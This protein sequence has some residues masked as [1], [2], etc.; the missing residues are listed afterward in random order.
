MAAG[1]HVALD[2]FGLGGI[3]DGAEKEGFA[4]LAA[5]VLGR[6]VLDEIDLTG[7]Q[8]GYEK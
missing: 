5:E 3:H 2:C 1:G 7:L 8:A 6:M 4:V